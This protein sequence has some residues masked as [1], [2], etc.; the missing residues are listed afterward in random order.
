MKKVV[1]TCVMAF[2]LSLVSNVQANDVEAL[3]KSKNCLSC[4]AVDRKLVGPAY[5]EIAKGKDP[6]GGEI[7]IERLVKSI[8]GGSMGKW[9]PIPM[10]PNPVTDDEAKQ[11]AEWIMSL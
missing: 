10:P 6:K 11:L 1:L 3:A 5:K 7:T 2:G 8:K 9:G 4:H